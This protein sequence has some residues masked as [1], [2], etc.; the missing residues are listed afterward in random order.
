MIKKILKE[1]KKYGL[2]IIVIGVFLIVQE[3]I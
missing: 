1:H 2:A 3:W